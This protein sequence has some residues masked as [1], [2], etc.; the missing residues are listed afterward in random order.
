MLTTVAGGLVATGALA[1]ATWAGVDR[2]WM[3]RV[4]RP[5]HA[6]VVPQPASA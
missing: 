3:L 1:Y 6:P 4:A 2:L 5:P